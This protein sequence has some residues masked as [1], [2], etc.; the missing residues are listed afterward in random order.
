MRQDLKL[1]LLNITLHYSNKLVLV[2]NYLKIL[3]F[4]K[5]IYECTKN[6]KTYICLAFL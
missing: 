6:L 2:T 1:Y 3:I 4:D 5:K